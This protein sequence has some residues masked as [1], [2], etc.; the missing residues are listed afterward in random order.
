[1]HTKLMEEKWNRNVWKKNG[2]LYLTA[3]REKLKRVGEL[4]ILTSCV[5]LFY[6]MWVIRI[7]RRI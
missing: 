1:M 6:E 3:E 2:C 7:G 4:G 5:L